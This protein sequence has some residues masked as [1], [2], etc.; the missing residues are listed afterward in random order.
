VLKR[1]RLKRH[2]KMQVAEAEPCEI[3]ILV[4]NNL[5]LAAFSFD[6]KPPLND[7]SEA[8]DLP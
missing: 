1:A 3:A 5:G 2:I 7:P 8:E 6:P 4:A